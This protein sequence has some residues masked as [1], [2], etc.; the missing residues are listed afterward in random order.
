MLTLTGPLDIFDRFVKVATDLAKVPALVMPQYRSAAQ[1]L[2]RIT[3]LLM[4]A[5]ENLARWLNRFLYFDFRGADARGRFLALLVEYRT[6][7]AGPEFRTLKF[8]C[9]DIG[10]IYHRDIASKL[11]SWLSDPQKLSQARTAFEALADADGDMVQYT[12]HV[13]I[14]E[15]DKQVL[16]ME[17]AVEAGDLDAA[18]KA[19]LETKSD[20]RELSAKLD[21]FSGAM[22]ELVL[23]F[24]DVAKAPL[25]ASVAVT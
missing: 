5:N 21:A 20:F 11:G 7:K 15:L 12:Y 19:R 14:T 23:S 8:S 6:M 10:R 17:A 18:E 3:R 25:T 13:V 9:G 22:A 16:V 24:A 4:T 2:Y 1:D